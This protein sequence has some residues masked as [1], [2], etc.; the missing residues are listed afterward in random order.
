MKMNKY[1]DSKNDE[2]NDKQIIEDLKE[3]ID[4]YENGEI[5]E[6]RDLLLDIINS[7]DEFNG[8]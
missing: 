4:M 5:L 8:G 1:Y 3:A 7:I 6:V 2:L